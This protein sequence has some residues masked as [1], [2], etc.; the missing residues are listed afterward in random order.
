LSRTFLAALHESR[1]ESR[2]KKIEKGMTMV[3]SFAVR[4][5]LQ[6]EAGIAAPLVF[7]T[8]MMAVL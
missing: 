4:T 5:S 7:R 8:L 2:L 3:L 1:Y 6:S